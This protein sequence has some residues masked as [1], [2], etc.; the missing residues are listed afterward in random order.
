MYTSYQRQKRKKIMLKQ[1]ERK[2][3]L[4]AESTP[5]SVL[6]HRRSSMRSTVDGKSRSYV[7]DD[8]SPS[9]SVQKSKYTLIGIGLDYDTAN[10]IDMELLDDVKGRLIYGASA[11]TQIPVEGV[12]LVG[13]VCGR[14]FYPQG[15]TKSRQFTRVLT[16]KGNAAEC[17]TIW[18]IG[19]TRTGLVGVG[20]E[21]SFYFAPDEKSFFWKVGKMEKNFDMPHAKT[22]GLTADDAWATTQFNIGND[23]LSNILIMAADPTARVVMGIFYC[24]P[25]CIMLTIALW[26]THTAPK[27]MTVKMYKLDSV[28]EWLCVISIYSSIFMKDGYDLGT[29]FMAVWDVYKLADKVC[30]NEEA[31]GLRIAAIFGFVNILQIPLSFLLSM[32]IAIF[33]SEDLFLNVLLNVVALE[34]VTEIDDAMVSSFISRRYSDHAEISF[35]IL[36][37]TYASDVNEDIDLWHY[38]DSSKNRVLN[39]LSEGELSNGM[40]WELL[41]SSEKGLGLLGFTKQHNRKC[42][43]S[44][45]LH[46][47]IIDWV[48]LSDDQL[49][50]VGSLYLAGTTSLT[51]EHCIGFKKRALL[52]KHYPEQT[53]NFPWFG[54]NLDGFDLTAQHVP[55]MTQ[56]ANKHT[57]VITLACGKS[58]IGD[59]SAVRVLCDG[60]VENK[61]LKNLSLTDCDLTDSCAMTIGSFLR[62]NT[63]LETIWLSRNKNIGDTGALSLLAAISEGDDANKTLHYIIMGW[64]SVSPE[65][66]D[67]CARVAHGRMLFLSDECPT[68]NSWILREIEK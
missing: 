33:L 13:C 40:R 5:V 54:L 51:W 34:F 29:Q 26:V 41:T 55:F 11:I 19:D 32:F 21:V 44:F 8:D 15:G 66:Q 59:S 14:F 30:D 52:F 42:V 27:Y 24:V 64:N 61:T 39:Q 10:G 9:S 6:R 35:T 68:I 67:K 1:K 31:R 3:G 57:E 45:K 46:L 17:E 20:T 38:S 56:I 25:Y 22:R 62:G 2:E 23:F 49:L 18:N 4:V 7:V 48:T 53:V 65:C 60:L 58:K 37:I 36:D 12:L 50:D 63:S 47:G 43:S 28:L 16:G